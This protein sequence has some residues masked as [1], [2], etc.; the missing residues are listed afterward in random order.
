MNQ[1][2]PNGVEIALNIKKRSRA[3]KKRIRDVFA[4]AEVSYESYKSWRGGR[5]EPRNRTVQKVDAVLKR[6][7][8]GPADSAEQI[9]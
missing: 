5:I 8:E 9:A 2:L 4:E 7:E 1:S 3:L 6:H